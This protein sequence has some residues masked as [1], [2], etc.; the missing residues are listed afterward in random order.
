MGRTRAGRPIT[1]VQPTVFIEARG[2]RSFSSAFVR[3]R[4]TMASAI[5]STTPGSKPPVNRAAMDTPVT[6][7]MA[8]STK[9]GGMVSA[10]APDAA[11]R[12]TI[13]PS[14]SPRFFIS[15]NSTGATAAMS[16]A[17]EPEMPETSSMPPSST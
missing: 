2:A 9:D 8:I 12:E 1:N 11:S 13:S 7:A 17:L 14:F 4:A 3:C 6:E 10:M 15:G 5:A 16:A